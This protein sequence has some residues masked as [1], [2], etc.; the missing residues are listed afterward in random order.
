M[1]VQNKVKNL[2][3]IKGKNQSFQM[4]SVVEPNEEVQLDFAG[5]LPDELNK[6]AYILVAIDKSSKFPTTKFVSNTTAYIAIKFMQRYISNNGVRGQLGCNQAQIFRAKTIQLF[7][8]TNNI[9]LLFA[10]VNGHRAIGVVER[11]IQTL[12][13]RLGV[14]GMDPANTPYKLA[15]DV[16]EIDKTLRITPHGV[17]KISPFETHIS[18]KPNTSLSHLATTSSPTNLNWENA[19]HA[20]LHWK[21]LTNPP[22]PAEIMH[23]LPNWSEDEVS[24]NQRQP[25]QP[26]PCT[27][28]KTADQPPGA[29]C[30]RY[31]A[32]NI[33]R[34]N[35]RYKGIQTLT[36]KNVSKRLEQV[37]RKI[38]RVA[39]KVQDPKTFQQKYKTIEG[40]I[41]PNTPHTACAQDFGKQP[42]LLRNSGF[43]FVPNPLIYG[44]F[45]PS[46][47]SD[48]EA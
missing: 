19:K 27:A 14:M 17:T 37:A 36:D 31:I 47:L 42:R 21:N 1:T 35:N 38:I 24:I 8:N 32:L 13:C 10:P 15:S 39:T 45:R 33:D 4:D 18:R 12:K 43:A 25:L 6:D 44:P 16:A 41:L 29:K 20:C 23:D 7:C 26:Q 9:K 40:K 5:P 30:K 11:M 46:R 2:K 28:S 22:L 3:P 34:V 48:Y